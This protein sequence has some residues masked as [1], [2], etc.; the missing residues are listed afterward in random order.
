M[1]VKIYYSKT[2]QFEFQQKQ[3]TSKSL[4]LEMKAADINYLAELGRSNLAD[5]HGS[6]G[7]KYCYKLEPFWSNAIKC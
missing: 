6:T 7:Q 5:H 2:N 3:L 1:I 4:S